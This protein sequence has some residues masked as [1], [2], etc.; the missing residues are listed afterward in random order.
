MDVK[1]KALYD[2]VPMTVKQIDIILWIS[3]GALAVVV[4]LILLEALGIFKIG[5]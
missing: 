2:K 4:V 3:L 5:G 1:K